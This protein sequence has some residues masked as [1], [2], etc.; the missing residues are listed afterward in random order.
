M[1]FHIIQSNEDYARFI[2]HFD[3]IRTSNLL[4][5]LCGSISALMLIA[6][7]EVGTNISTSS[8]NCDSALSL[9]VLGL[10][11]IVCH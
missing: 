1:S 6:F 11:S 3:P 10:L 2:L 9:Q 5:G 7:N 4:V 8:C